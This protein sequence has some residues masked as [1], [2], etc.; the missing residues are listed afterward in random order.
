M[1]LSDERRRAIDGRVTENAAGKF[2]TSRTALAFFYGIFL[3]LYEIKFLRQLVPAVHPVLIGWAAA[4]ICYDLLIRGAWKTVPYYPIFVLFGI[5]AAV[6]ALIHQD[7]GLVGNL[8]SLVMSVLPLLAFYPVCFCR[9]R[10]KAMFL[11]L[12][13][14]AVVVFLASVIGVVL[15]LMRFSRV[16][17]FLGMEEL[18][19]FR[20]Y[21]ERFENSG[22]IHYGIYSDTNHAAAYAVIFAAYSAALYI[23]CRRGIFRGRWQNRLGMV[24]GAANVIAQ[25]CYF[26]L[27]NSRGGWLSLYAAGAAAVFCYLLCGRQRRGKTAVRAVASALV[28]VL[29]AA[30][31]CLMVLFLRSGL[32]RASLLAE[33][34]SVV[35]TEPT[36]PAVETAA[37]DSF[38]KVST[39][40]AGGRLEI[41]QEAV[42][43]YSHYPFFG[44]GPGNEQHYALKFFDSGT[45][46]YGKAIHNSYLDLLVGYGGVG[47]VIL[48]TFFG[49]C[50]VTA[51]KKLFSGGRDAVEC[52]ALGSVIMA[53][54]AAFFLSCAFVSATAMYFLLLV[55]TGYLV[56]GREAAWRAGF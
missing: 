12:L 17:S 36:V 1:F 55:L 15:Y 32:S 5:S 7:A 30:L 10:R 39:S 19:G 40:I 18:I 33:R 47:F 29:A 56:S 4:L 34:A 37:P 43:L 14:A 53:A 21:D 2:L 11:A 38:D 23:A 31:V 44:I 42:A 52:L 24:F 46:I 20:L 35:P 50:T 9:E 25:L 16:V 54:C 48:M 49:L 27:A 13:G 8:K 51:L 6:T 22:I 26:P 3:F 41:W 28:S 45:L